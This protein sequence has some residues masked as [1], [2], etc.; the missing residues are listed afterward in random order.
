ME[1]CGAQLGVSARALCKAQADERGED[2]ES[3]CLG[4]IQALPSR[5]LCIYSHSTSVT[6]SFLQAL[7]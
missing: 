6:L 2:L 5:Q 7:F 3:V 1:H 4:W